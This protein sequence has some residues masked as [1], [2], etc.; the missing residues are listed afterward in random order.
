MNK[1]RI[2]VSKKKQRDA[3]LNKRWVQKE[4]TVLDEGCFTTTPSPK[5]NPAYV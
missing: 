5:I 2:T 3:F 4:H 1:E